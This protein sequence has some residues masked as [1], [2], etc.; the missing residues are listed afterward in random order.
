[1][2]VQLGIGGKR[3]VGTIVVILE[4][5]D[6]VFTQ[7]GNGN[8]LLLTAGELGALSTNFGIKT[9]ANARASAW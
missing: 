6:S 4:G 7:G 8:A 1:M 3:L 2:L 5:K 9:T